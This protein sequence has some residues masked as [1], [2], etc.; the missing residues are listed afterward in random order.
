MMGN[1]KKCKIKILRTI[2]TI[3]EAA[4]QKKHCSPQSRELQLQQQPGQP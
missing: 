1:K 3:A 4:F 2:N